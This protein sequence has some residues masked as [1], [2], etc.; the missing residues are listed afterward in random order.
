MQLIEQDLT[1]YEYASKISMP[2]PIMESDVVTKTI[3]TQV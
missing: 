3:V 1:V 2:D